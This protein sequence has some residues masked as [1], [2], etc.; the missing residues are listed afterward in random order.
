MKRIVLFFTLLASFVIC[1]A[2]KH[3][4]SST[5][6]HQFDFWIGEWDVYGKNGKKA[7]D[8]KITAILDSCVILEEWTSTNNTQGI[9]YSGKSFNK[10]NAATDQWQQTW[11][12]NAGGSTEFL[13]GIYTSNKIVFSTNPFVVTKDT[14]AVR[15]LTF[16][17]LGEAK[18]RQLGE[19]SKDN[20]KTWQ[21]EYDLE[22]RRKQ[23]F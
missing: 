12:D 1:N 2:Q 6:Y 5:I 19:I 18:V 10:Y 13:K 8:S 22:Y 17:N 9:I 3:P 7:G 20:E 15:R 21:T 14:M 11:V 16:F 23:S 4:C